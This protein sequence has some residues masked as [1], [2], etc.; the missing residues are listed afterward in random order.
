MPTFSQQTVISTFAPLL[1]KQG[2]SFL[3]QF[4]QFKH[5]RE[6]EH[7]V[8]SRGIALDLWGKIPKR[9][10]NSWFPYIF[11][12]CFSPLQPIPYEYSPVTST[13]DSMRWRPNI[14]VLGRARHFACVLADVLF[15]TLVVIL[16]SSVLR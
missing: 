5:A 14:E 6:H 11:N 4:N 7:A 1:L 16:S 12:L 2:H 3:N 10:I 15:T 8:S 9:R 13:P